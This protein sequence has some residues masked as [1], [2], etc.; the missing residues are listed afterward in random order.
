MVYKEGQVALVD[1]PFQKLQ[2][3]VHAVRV[4]WLGDSCVVF[5]DVFRGEKA[6]ASISCIVE[7]GSDE[8]GWQPHARN[9]RWTD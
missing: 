5:K 4:K 7:G 6:T 2:A 1:N 9:C 8:L 3:L